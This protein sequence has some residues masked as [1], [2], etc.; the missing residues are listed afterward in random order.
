[1]KEIQL[2]Q[3]KVA[4]VD[5]EDYDYLIHKRW[6]CN[7]M[8]GKYYS[9]SYQLINDRY[10][11]ISM[12]RFI[13]KPAKGVFVDHINGDGLDNRKCN[14]RLCSIAE[15]NCNRLKNKNN[16]S[17]YKGVIWHKMANKWQAYI[18]YQNKKIYIGLF[19]N[20]EDAAIAYNRA[21]L[22]Y[23]GNFANLNQIDTNEKRQLSL[24]L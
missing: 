1:M 16:T 5:D 10:S 12:H 22:K 13:M 6:H 7:L 14:L 23:H 3:G 8:N 17:G 9:R 11:I 19:Y 18:K 21:A 15:N 2:S 24:E 20:I 4:I